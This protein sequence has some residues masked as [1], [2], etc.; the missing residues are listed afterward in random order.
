MSYHQSGA[1]KPVFCVF[2]VRNI[3]QPCILCLTYVMFTQFSRI[4]YI[5]Q[6]CRLYNSDIPQTYSKIR[7]GVYNSVVSFR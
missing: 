6:P 2:L 4:V 3:T 1:A 7:N 5:S